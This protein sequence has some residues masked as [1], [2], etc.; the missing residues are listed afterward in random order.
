[1]GL[2]DAWDKVV[3]S[4][5]GVNDEDEFETDEYEEEDTEDRRKRRSV[6]PAPAASAPRSSLGYAAQP[7][8]P[9]KMMIVE[10]ESFDDSQS[11]AD[12][13][14]DRKPVVINFESTDPD[15]AKRVVDFIS[16]ATYALDGN[17]QKVGKDIFLCVPSNVTV[18]RGKRDYGEFNTAPLAWNGGDSN[19]GGTTT[20]Q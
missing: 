8:Q 2:K 12:Y 7:A 15:V 16:G 18:D 10:P 1:M 5:S 17:I 13:L 14:R 20:Q 3:G 11:I 6:P 4:I 19:D 9:L